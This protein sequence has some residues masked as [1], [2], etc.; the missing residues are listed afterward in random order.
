MG[1]LET[2][3]QDINERLSASSVHV[4][5]LARLARR[6]EIVFETSDDIRQR[7]DAARREAQR[8]DARSARS[9]ALFKYGYHRRRL[10]AFLQPG[11]RAGFV[12]A[13]L[14]LVLEHE[15][16]SLREEVD[17][18]EERIR[19]L[20]GQSAKHQMLMNWRDDIIASLG[21]DGMPAAQQALLRVS[22]AVEVAERQEDAQVLGEAAAVASLALLDVEAALDDLQG[23]SRLEEE[24]VGSLADLIPETVRHYPVRQAKRRL[25]QATLRFGFVQDELEAV[26]GLNVQVRHPYW[27]LEEY[28][29]GAFD[30]YLAGRAPTEALVAVEDARTYAHRLVDALEA[31]HAQA[32]E[33]VERARGKE[34]E[35]VGHAVER[36]APS[37]ARLRGRYSSWDALY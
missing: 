4:A 13:G 9:Q 19:S 3:L 27:A 23:V 7:L 32:L 35:A 24:D 25:E 37:P 16:R 14:Y 12:A 34:L 31:A 26:E 2:R 33:H 1:T 18:L 29:G 10:E 20:G 36:V 8:T 21:P 15:L 28:L 6:R 30:D 5:Q 11:A 22:A 17:A